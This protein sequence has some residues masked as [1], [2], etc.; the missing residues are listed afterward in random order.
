VLVPEGFYVFCSSAVI[1]VAIIT[2][3]KD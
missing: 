2:G 3:Q 1:L